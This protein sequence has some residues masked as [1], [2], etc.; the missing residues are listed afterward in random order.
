MRQNF[1]K[2]GLAL[3]VATGSVA[4]N[5]FSR[6]E[7]PQA[8]PQSA[9]SADNPEAARQAEAKEESWQRERNIR[10]CIETVCQS[11]YPLIPS[12]L[13]GPI[14]DDPYGLE[15]TILKNFIDSIKRGEEKLFKVSGEAPPTAEITYYP[16]DMNMDSYQ[17]YLVSI[18]SVILSGRSRSQKFFAIYDKNSKKYT[19]KNYEIDYPLDDF[20]IGLQ[21]YKN[22]KRD[23][24]VSYIEE[25]G[26][27]MH[28][29]SKELEWN[30]ISCDFSY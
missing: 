28:S 20:Y 3:A 6:A 2:W 8:I 24:F 17:D 7:S 13:S 19:L 22:D 10:K 16:F 29:P 26:L 15:S 12:P 27:K 11:A 4:V 25:N 14:G 9:V 21:C 18:S 5:G 23:I 30:H 1:V